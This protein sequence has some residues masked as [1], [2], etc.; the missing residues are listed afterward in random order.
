MAGPS[1]ERGV[2]DG[3]KIEGGGARSKWVRFR[4]RTTL[5]K[6]EDSGML[7]GGVSLDSPGQQRRSR[8]RLLRVSI[9]TLHRARM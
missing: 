3:F 1:V 9:V 7:D 2:I 6:T 4:P 5:W 8:C